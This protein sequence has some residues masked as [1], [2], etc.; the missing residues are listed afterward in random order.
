[1]IINR[2]LPAGQRAPECVAVCVS[3]IG[4]MKQERESREVVSSW[5]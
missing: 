1:M 2:C 5:G 4:Q 3:L